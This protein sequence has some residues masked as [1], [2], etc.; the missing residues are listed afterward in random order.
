MKKTPKR[1][2]YINNICICPV[3]QLLA[4]SCNIPAAFIKNA[5]IPFHKAALNAPTV[6]INIKF[7]AE[8][9]EFLGNTAFILLTK[10]YLKFRQ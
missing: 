8:E 1:I 2:F 9:R 4:D 7:R 5:V 3:K 6:E 10:I